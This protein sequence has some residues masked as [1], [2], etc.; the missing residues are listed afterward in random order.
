MTGRLAGKTAVVTG[1]GRGIGRACAVALA[2][3]GADLVLVDVAADLPGVPYPMATRSQLDCTAELCRERGAAVLTAP[4]DVRDPEACARVV[5]DAVDRFGGVD[6][7]VNNAGIAGP[8]GRV[9]HEVTEDEWA[10]MIDVNL[11]GAWRMLKAAG[12]VMAAARSGS[13]VNIASTAGLVGYRS[14]AGYVASKHGLVGLTKAAALDYAPYRVRVNAVCPGSV[15]DSAEHEGRMLV[16]IGRSIGIAPDDHEAEF[17]TQQPM[18]ALVEAGDVAAAVLWLATDES[19]HA[20]GGVITVD[21]GYS[22]R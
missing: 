8:S 17:V 4:A 18:N 19:R 15:R 14:F 9:V 16:E 6:V 7:L 2:A 5:A 1:A 3:E 22:A 12:A 13:V 11:N 20:T 10:V 21:G